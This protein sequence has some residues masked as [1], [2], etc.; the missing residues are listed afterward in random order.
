MHRLCGEG[1]KVLPVLATVLVAVS[2][3]SP[4][5]LHHTRDHTIPDI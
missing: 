4:T 3:L 2:R 1:E 5:L